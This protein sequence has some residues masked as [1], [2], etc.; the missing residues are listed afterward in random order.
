MI[1]ETVLTMAPVR[2]KPNSATGVAG[3]STTMLMAAAVPTPARVSSSRVPNRLR[4][5][6]PISRPQSI[7]NSNSG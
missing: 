7:A 6:S 3:A 5:R 4:S 2:K 1:G